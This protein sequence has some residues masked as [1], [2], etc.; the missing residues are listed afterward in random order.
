M[1]HAGDRGR[2]D[3]RLDDRRHLGQ[4]S[5]ALPPQK[6]ACSRQNGRFFWRV[7]PGLCLP[8]TWTRLVATQRRFR[9]VIPVAQMRQAATRLA[10][11]APPH[12]IIFASMCVADGRSLTSALQVYATIAAHMQRVSLLCR[13]GG[14]RGGGFLIM[15]HR[16]WQGG[17][18]RPRMQL[19]V[20][21]R[22]HQAAGLS[23]SPSRL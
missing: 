13:T 12:P 22:G 15:R 3:A 6:V 21:Q 4:A 16:Q 23:Q 19:R 2:A 17:L 7:M 20:T 14:G 18:R 1:E 11:L 9:P 8:V 5:A 10:S